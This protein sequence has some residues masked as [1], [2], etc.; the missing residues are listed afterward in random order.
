MP[1][2]FVSTFSIIGVFAVTLQQ[3]PGIIRAI[4]P[5]NVDPF[6]RNSGTLL[7][8]FLEKSFGI[9]TIVL[10]V[11]VTAKVTIPPGLKTAFLYVAFVVLAAYYLF[12]ILYYL[13]I[14]TLPVLIGMAAF[15]PVCYLFIALAQGNYPAIITTVIFGIIH[16]G[17]T[18][19]NFKT[20]K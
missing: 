20:R 11:F 8:E 4:Y 5:P 18:Y 19:S 17:L 12:Y 10:I 2:W 16:I 14:T 3:I 13:K 15:P 9:A 7:I 6:S 1:N